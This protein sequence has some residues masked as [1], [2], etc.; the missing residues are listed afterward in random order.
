VGPNK[1]YDNAF[2][3]LSRFDIVKAV[4]G[5]LFFKF[6]KYTNK[7]IKCN[8]L[9]IGKVYTRSNDLTIFNNS[10]KIS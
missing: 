4:G 9:V 8:I 6:R 5:T 3:I 7:N 1:K 2:M 10:I